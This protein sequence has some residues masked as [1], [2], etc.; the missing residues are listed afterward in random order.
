MSDQTEQINSE[1][2]PIYPGLTLPED[3]H[4]IILVDEA[5]YDFGGNLQAAYRLELSRVIPNGTKQGITYSLLATGDD[6]ADIA[7]PDASVVPA[8]VESFDPWSTK[9]AQASDETT[10]AKFLIISLNQN[11]DDAYVIQAAGFYSFPTTH[12]YE[13]GKT[14]YLSDSAPGGVTNVAPPGIVQ[15]LF[16]VI[17]NKTILIDIG[18]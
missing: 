17:D 5:N 7:I 18:A 16:Y 1:D 15:P 14:Y 3:A 11:V 10:K 9:R 6:G 12:E 13:V 8:Y 2:L 4:L